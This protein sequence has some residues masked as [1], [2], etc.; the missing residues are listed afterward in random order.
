MKRSLAL[1]LLTAA[2][3]VP[4]SAQRINIDLP[5]FRELR[6]KAAE[7]VTVT[8]DARMLRLA[9]KFLSD[10]DKDQRSA[11]DI[12]QKLEGIYVRSYEFDHDGEYDS[13]LVD[14]LRSQ[15]G[16]AN[17]NK[18]VDVRSRTRE[19]AEIYTFTRGETIAGL[20]VITAEPRE[21]T[22]VNIVG[23]IDLDRLSDLDGQFGIPK[24]KKI[25]KE[26]KQ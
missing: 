2:L 11:R 6:D 1:L 9:A 16:G 4:A 24:V 7:E 21:L 20:V 3:S 18:I 17:W 14:R 25:V 12:V 10:N 5:E 19:N 26:S 23:P 8:L 15:L 13:S 22:I